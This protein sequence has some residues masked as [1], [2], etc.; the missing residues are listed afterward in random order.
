MDTSKEYVKMC[1]CPEVRDMIQKIIE[2]DRKRRVETRARFADTQYSIRI[3]DMTTPDVTIYNE[4]DDY[5]RRVDLLS[6]DQIQEMMGHTQPG[7]LAADGITLQLALK[8]DTWEKF[9]LAFYMFEKHSK[10]WD[11]EKW[12]SD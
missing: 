1:D 8:H 9:W 7:I 6:Q 4:K 2:S 10:K 12:L 5:L 11:G 3:P